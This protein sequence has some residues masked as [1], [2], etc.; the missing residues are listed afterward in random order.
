MASRYINADL[1]GLGRLAQL[2]DQ[3]YRTPDT[4]L[5][6]EIRLQERRFGL[7]PEDRNRLQWRITD[8]DDKVKPRA[9]KRTESIDPRKLLKAV[10]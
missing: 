8:P 3:F 6:A 1:Y 7:S 4:A 9:I 10:K 2:V 5:M